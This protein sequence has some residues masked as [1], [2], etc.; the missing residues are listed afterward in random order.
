[1][2]LRLP[3]VQA[4]FGA[5]YATTMFLL[6]SWPLLFFLWVATADPEYP[7]RERSRYAEALH[8][9]VEYTGN[10]LPHGTVVSAL[11][12]AAIGVKVA[13][14]SRAKRIGVGKFP[15]KR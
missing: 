8:Q 13:R 1:M 3:V 6:V 14:R 9:A 7:M 12:G 15:V 2:K 4:T 5:V 10:Y 11:V